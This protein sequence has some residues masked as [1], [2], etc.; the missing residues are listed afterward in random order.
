MDERFPPDAVSG[1]RRGAEVYDEGHLRRYLLGRLNEEEQ[2]AIEE[3]LLADDELFDLL[4]SAEDELIDDYVSGAL[5]AEER[6]GFEGFF[7][8]TSERQR[9]LSF[10]M[11]LRRYITTESAVTTQAE[12]AESSSRVIARRSPVIGARW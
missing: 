1:G 11:A 7:L 10:A 6:K 2:Q 5:S 4:A 12:S 8:S 9:K 3:A